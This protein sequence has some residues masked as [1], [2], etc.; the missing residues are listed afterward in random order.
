[1]T[2]FKKV[3]DEILT[4]LGNVDGVTLKITVEIEAITDDGFSEAKV[5]TISENARELK[6]GD[7]GFES[8]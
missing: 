5:R 8:G 1:V 2:D 3:Y 6:F 7:S 4:P